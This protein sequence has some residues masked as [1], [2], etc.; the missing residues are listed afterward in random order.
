MGTC[1][2]VRQPLRAGGRYV[3]SLTS[4]H[5]A[6]QETKGLGGHVDHM[7]SVSTA[8]PLPPSQGPQGEA[9]AVQVGMPCRSRESCD[10]ETLTL[11]GLPPPQPLPPPERHVSFTAKAS[12]GRA[13]DVSGFVALEC[14]PAAMSLERDYF[15][16]PK[17]ACC[18]N[19]LEQSSQYLEDMQKHQV[20]GELSPSKVFLYLLSGHTCR[21]ACVCQKFSVSKSQAPVCFGVFS[22][23]D[24]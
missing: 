8:V 12:P 20:Y 21:Q 22:L 6:G 1:P 2:G 24:L 9:E 7:S 17:A 18:E 13:A 5:V 14:L 16:L 4:V 23:C 15:H 10:E 3:A 19:V 11:G